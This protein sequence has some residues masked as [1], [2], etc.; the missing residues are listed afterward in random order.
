MLRDIEI[1]KPIQAAFSRANEYPGGSESTV[2]ELAE[3]FCELELSNNSEV[4][5]AILDEKSVL[6]DSVYGTAGGSDA[7]VSLL[8]T[9][10]VPAFGMSRMQTCIAGVKD[11]VVEFAVD[12]RRPRYADWIRV[13]EDKIVVIERYW[14]LREIGVNP[15]VEY[16]RDRHHRQV[17]MPK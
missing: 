4:A 7:I 6:I 16:S 15:F 1:D 10:P 8:K 5:D 11:A 9:T 2:A 12:P 17:I 3:K 13:V 14:M